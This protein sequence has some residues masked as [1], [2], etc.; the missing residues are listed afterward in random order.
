MFG[1]YLKVALRNLVKHKGYSFI[2]I[3]G[4]GVGMACC[5]FIL[6]YIKQELSY[7]TFHT[8]A[9]RIYRIAVE[10]EKPKGTEVHGDCPGRRG[11]V[12]KMSVSGS[13]RLPWR[14]RLSQRCLQQAATSRQPAATYCCTPSAGFC[15]ADA[16]FS[17][18]AAAFG[19]FAGGG[20]TGACATERRNLPRECT[21][22][23]YC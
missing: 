1:N 9:D 22:S 17:A 19:C 20:V 15:S 7:D 10:I 14:H 12:I 18:L 16:A 21:P 11:G 23:A 8:K 3:V 6:L 5:I 13:R 4:L 2:N